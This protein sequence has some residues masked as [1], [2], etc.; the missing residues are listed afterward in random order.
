MKLLVADDDRIS[1]LKLVKILEKWGYE[2][3]ACEDGTEAWK[4][5]QEKDSR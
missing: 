1:R 5:I 3:I 2:V 4:K